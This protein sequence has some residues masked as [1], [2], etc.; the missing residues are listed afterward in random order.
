[1]RR[2]VG[3]SHSGAVRLVDRLAADGLVARRPATDAR[4][5]AL[6]LTPAGREGARR[7]LGERQ[8]AIVALLAALTDEERDRLVG[9]LEKLLARLTSDEPSKRRLCRLCDEAACLED[10]SCPV[11]QA[12]R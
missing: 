2:V 7:A 6:E 11:D 1:V 5:V 3:P 9:A 8:A 10:A 12:G 4:A